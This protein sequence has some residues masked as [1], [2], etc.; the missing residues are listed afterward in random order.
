M[1]HIS[2]FIMVIL[3]LNDFS[4]ESLRPAHAESK[5]AS[6]STQGQGLGHLVRVQFRTRTRTKAKGS[7]RPLWEVMY[8]RTKVGC[9]CCCC[10]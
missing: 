3:F 6:I 2:I 5:V 7:D 8:C 10:L 4:S 1:I 9:C